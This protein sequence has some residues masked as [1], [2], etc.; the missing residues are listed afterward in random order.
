MKYKYKKS[1][2]ILQWCAEIIFFA[3][4]LLLL[5]YK[6]GNFKL[7]IKQ[8]V[9]L[10][11]IL[12]VFISIYT[13]EYFNRYIEFKNEYVVFNSFRIPRVKKVQNFNVR[14]EDFMS[15][16]STSIPILGLYKVKIRAKNVPWVIPV[17]FCMSNHDKLFYDLCSC[18]KKYN[19]GIYIDDRLLQYFEKKEYGKIN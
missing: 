16:E 1:A 9:S 19:P 17:T 11:A 18:A 2:I 3:C 5:Y 4:L 13:P 15:L 7:L 10:S 8:I 14:Y 12:F 6:D